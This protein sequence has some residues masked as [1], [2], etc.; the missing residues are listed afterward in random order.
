MTATDTAEQTV[1]DEAVEALLAAHDPAEESRVEFRG[2]QYD[3]GLAWVHHPVGF[4]GLG[5]SP[6]L[7]RP[8]ERQLRAGGAPPAD[9]STFFLALIG[10]TIVTHGTD[11][12]KRRYLRPNVHRRGALVPAVQRARLGLG[13]RRVGNPR[14]T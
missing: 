14:R 4:G 11:E 7:Q 8:A 10:P 3:A 9:P 2:H 5:V 6:R 1:V 13:L 12:Q